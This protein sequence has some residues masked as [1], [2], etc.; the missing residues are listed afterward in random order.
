M[1]GHQRAG[2]QHGPREGKRKE[3]GIIKRRNEYDGE[4]SFVI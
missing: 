1:Q 3:R 4:N 2:S